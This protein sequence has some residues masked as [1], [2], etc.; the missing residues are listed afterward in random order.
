MADFFLPRQHSWMVRPMGFPERPTT[1]DRGPVRDALLD[2]VDAA[3][4]LEH[5]RTQLDRIIASAQAE[6]EDA[7]KGQP[8]LPDGEFWGGRNTPAVYHEFGN[9]VA[10]T[11]AVDDRY[12]KNRL[13]PT[14]QHDPGLLRDLQEIRRSTGA[15][16]Q[17]EEARRLAR[18]SLHKFTPPYPGAGAKVEGGVLVY[19]VPI[20]VDPDDFRANRLVAG[21]HVVSVDDLWAAVER[22]VDQL[23]DVFYPRKDGGNE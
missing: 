18:V 10:W 23:L 21:R 9:A 8:S 12:R 6:L 16:A 13:L 3:G 20:I 7:L 15:G 22:F 1:G 14:V 5:S 2:V 4:G 11:R 19:P 17:F